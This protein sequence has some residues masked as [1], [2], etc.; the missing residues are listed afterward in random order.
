VIN[1]PDQLGRDKLKKRHFS[2][3]FYKYHFL[4]TFLGGLAVDA[5]FGVAFS[6]SI[7]GPKNG[8][9]R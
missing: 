7:E 8:K 3:I 1:F 9:N 4:T 5:D 6:G 2:I